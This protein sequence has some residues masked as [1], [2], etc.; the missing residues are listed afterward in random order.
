MPRIGP[1]SGGG[2]GSSEA[3]PADDYVLAMVALSRKISRNGAEYLSCKWEVVAGQLKGSGFWSG[4]MLDL[5]KQGTVTRWQLLIEA[6]GITEDF[7][8]GSG[9]EGTA[10]EGDDNVRRLFFRKPFVARVSRERNG[11]YT[12]NT[13]ERVIP[14]RLWTQ[15]QTDQIFG[16]ITDHESQQDPE[17]RADD[18]SD[19]DSYGGRETKVSSAED[20][21]DDDDIPF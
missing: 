6:C 1:G 13:I 21:F 19:D 3:L 15:Q 10:R 2:G 18:P 12:N 4:L 8:L 9:E 16:Y 17:S 20:D 7:E 11:D 5:S 14:R